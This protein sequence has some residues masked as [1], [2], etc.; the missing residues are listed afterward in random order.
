MVTAAFRRL[1]DSYIL[2]IMST[3]TA[4]PLPQDRPQPTR[5]TVESIIVAFILAFLFRAF[6]AEAFVIPTGSMAPTLMGA[7]KDLSCVHC[8]MPYQ[9]SASAEFDSDT[10]ALTKQ[11]TVASMCANC[12][13]LNKYDFRHNPNHATFSGDRILVSKFDYVFS[14]PERWDVFVFKYPREARM[15]YIKRLVGLP[16]ERLLIREGDVYLSPLEGTASWTIARKPPHKIR[17]MR[18]IVFDTEHVPAKLIQAGWPGSWQPWG[19]DVDDRASGWV[20]ERSP[21]RWTA[22]LRPTPQTTFLRYFHK[23]LDVP[24]WEA[25]IDGGTLPE[26][27]PY[28]SRLITDYLAYN[29]R[30]TVSPADAIFDWKT[31]AWGRFLPS[32]LAPGPKWVLSEEVPEEKTAF[33]AA[34]ERGVPMASGYAALPDGLHWVGDLCGQFDVEVVSAEG[35][36]VLD[37]V[38]FGIHYRVEIDVASGEAKMVAL[39]GARKLPL[40]EE[41]PETTG[42]TTLRGPGR[43][44]VEFANFD[45]SLVLWIDGDVVHFDH[46]T[47]YDSRQ[48]RPG[49]DRRPYWS[50]EDPL[51][52]APVGIGGR[53]IDMTVRRARV[54]R[55]VYYIAIQ[56]IAGSGQYSALNYTDY[57]MRTNL[58]ARNDIVLD[59]QVRAQL[60]SDAEAVFAV[61]GQPQ[62]WEQTKLF[63]LRGTREFELREGEYFPMGDN[64]A[65]SSDARAWVGHHYV[66]QRFLLGKALLIFWPHT[67]NTP[68]PYTPNLQRMRLIR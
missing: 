19:G 58:A 41:N 13:G 36:L 7:H 44:C 47:E 54:Y 49:D 14:E 31:P 34:V 48:F 23:V 51:D 65:E 52:A 8:G 33:D 59:P 39:D 63:S 20:I 27:S 28:H 26:I 42:R 50:E 64:S 55:D 17:A 18:Q 16:G 4:L 6:V 32:F 22:R 15:N 60:H 68:V 12:R 45:D 62:W 67:W 35:T 11:K 56:R 40:F 2:A 46:S 24:H 10:G 25:F 37:L 29:S 21:D 3:S 61:Y 66:E 9:A 1:L 30:I 38:E 5:E 53:N 57:D 43:Y